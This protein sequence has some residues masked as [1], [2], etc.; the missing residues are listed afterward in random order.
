[1]E[2]RNS[3]T[4]DV[5]EYN[6]EPDRS[7]NIDVLTTIGKGQQFLPMFTPD[8]GFILILLLIFL[9]RGFCSRVSLLA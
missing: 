3:D 6:N 9:P 8:S 4:H 1:M 5:T 7:L 2:D